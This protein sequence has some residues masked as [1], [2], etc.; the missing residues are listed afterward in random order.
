MHCII[1]SHESPFAREADI[2][3]SL[4]QAGMKNFH[5]RKP[6]CTQEILQNIL[7]DIEPAYHSHIVLHDHF[8]LAKQFLLAG[9]HLNSRNPVCPSGA[10]AVSCGCHSLA[11]LNTLLSTFNGLVFLS[12]VFDS[13]SKQGYK[14]AFTDEELSAASKNKSINHR[15]IALGGMSAETIPLAASYGFGGVAVLGA[16]WGN[17]PV[18]KDKN[19]I[20]DHFL[21]LE[22]LT[23]QQ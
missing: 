21:Q 7:R 4:F 2:I 9:I 18:A 14:K 8:E 5:L 13:I 23:N 19:R 12:P 11:C 16:L 3:N 1:I 17:M 20:L 22:A 10:V 6:A 15:V